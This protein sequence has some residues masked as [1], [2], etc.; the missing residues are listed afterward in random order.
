M[1]VKTRRNRGQMIL[2]RPLPCQSRASFVDVVNYWMYDGET[3]EY[4]GVGRRH[5]QNAFRD[6]RAYDHDAGHRL[7]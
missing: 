3:R 5:A 7:S 4:D 6:P 1:R 2:T